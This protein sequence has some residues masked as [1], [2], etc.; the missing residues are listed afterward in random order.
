LA[1]VTRLCACLA[2]AAM[3]GGCGDAG[4]SVRTQPV[5]SATAQAAASATAQ[6]ATSATTQL[7]ASA[8]AQ[9]AAS[10]TAQ[11]AASATVVATAAPTR[12]PPPDPTATPAT[13]HIRST[14]GLPVYLYNSPT[15][16]D[17]IQTYPEGTPLLVV[18]SDVDGDGLTWHIVR[19]PDGTE[20]Y[21]P[22]DDT[23][24]TDTT[25]R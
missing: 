13:I 14:S 5:A 9:P 22:V 3:V 10:A 25:A 2:L 16:G 6:P 8:T 20:G 19:A 1:N 15:I 23:L 12:P 7:A 18:G 21:I 17:R 11:P 4:V 24:P